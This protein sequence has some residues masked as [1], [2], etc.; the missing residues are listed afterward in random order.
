MKKGSTRSDFV[1]PEDEGGIFT[2]D[3]VSMHKVN[4][5]WR[6]WHF[7]S[8]VTLAQWAVCSE[9]GWHEG[10]KCEEITIWKHLN[11]W[12]LLR[13]TGITLDLHFLIHTLRQTPHTPTSSLVSTSFWSDSCSIASTEMDM[14]VLEIIVGYFWLIILCFTA[15]EENNSNGSAVLLRLFGQNQLR[16]QR[17]KQKEGKSFF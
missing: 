15:T 7:K 16:G 4:V 11:D 14:M 8:Q 5:G 13:V 3:T 2:P 17:Q 12:L 6:R 9:A 1:S 10:I